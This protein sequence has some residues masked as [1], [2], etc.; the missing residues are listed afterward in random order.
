MNDDDTACHASLEEHQMT[1]PTVIG[2]TPIISVYLLL[3]VLRS[4]YHINVHCTE[5]KNETHRNIKFIR[6]KKKLYQLWLITVRNILN[7]RLN[8]T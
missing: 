2:S 6:Y 1:E 7:L 8:N 3:F 4:S 5:T